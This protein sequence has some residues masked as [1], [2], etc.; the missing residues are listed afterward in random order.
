[1]AHSKAHLSALCLVLISL[2]T[3]TYG[4][5]CAPLNLNERSGILVGD[6]IADSRT[7]D[8]RA[9][10]VRVVESVYGKTLNGEVKITQIDKARTCGRTL[11]VGDRR[12]FVIETRPGR[13]RYTLTSSL[14]LTL[15]HLALNAKRGMC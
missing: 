9:I 12:I 1:M 8:S 11:E 10:V 5:T 13:K 3:V 4:E 7:N 14:P 2:A 6:I 15:K